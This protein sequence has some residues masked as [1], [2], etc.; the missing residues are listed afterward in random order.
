MA[1]DDD[2]IS[3]GRFG[4]LAKLASLSAR[5]STDVGSR[6]VKRFANTSGEDPT[7]SLLGHGSAEKLVATL[8][9]LKGLA[10]KIGQTMSMDPDLLTPE[11]RAVMARLQN[12]APPMPWA[13]VRKV[14]TDELGRP[15]EE[16]YASFEE[17]PVAS[18]SL[19]QVHRA[20]TK[21]GV[22]VAVK[23]QYPDIAKAI[24]SDLKNVGAMVRVVATT[25]RL[26]HGTEYF[27]EVQQGLLEELDYEVEAER[28]RQFAEAAKPFPDLRVPKVFDELTAPRVLTLEFF[29][30][31]TVKEFLNHLGT[32]S[33][34]QRFHLSRLLVRVIWGPMLTS[35]VVH[36]DP[37]PGNFMLMRDGTLGV[38]DFGAIKQLSDRWG[39]ANRRLIGSFFGGPA[40]DAI[41]ESERAGMDF[42]DRDLARTFVESVLAISCRA[43][44]TETFD[45]AGAGLNRELRNLFIK[46]ALLL[47]NVRPPK[48]AIQFFRAI[49]G[50]NQ[51]LENL[52]ASGPF[53][54]VFAE[55]NAEVAN[56]G[57]P[58][59]SG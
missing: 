3:T 36:S 33:P 44:Q 39:T 40:Y 4:R 53:R 31:L 25:S 47:K 55:L 30:G 45:Y 2:T 9:D 42:G 6:L 54:H 8:G 11:I 29:D 20:V 41:V 15:P 52:G 49:A 16:A 56:S 17:Q 58:M 19:G 14:I 5:L 1:D 35:G 59:A 43:V 37:H 21:A 27:R 12:Q 28:S 46:N 50:A 22:T 7:V 18:A 24:E 38:L 34:A 48:E 51:N 57:R 32:H 26:T 10:M 23:V 13:T